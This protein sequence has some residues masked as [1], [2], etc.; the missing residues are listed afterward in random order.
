MTTAL[1]WDQEFT[2]DAT[3]AYISHQKWSDSDRVNVI[4]LK[5]LKSVE[6]HLP[7]GNILITEMKPKLIL[8]GIKR[9]FMME[10]I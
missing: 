2:L 3:L 9:R 10:S 6:I 7:K 8:G 5:P 4:G 1:F